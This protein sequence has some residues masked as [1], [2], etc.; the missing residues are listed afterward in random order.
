MESRVLIADDD[1]SIC[2]I[3]SKA[4]SKDGFVPEVVHRGQEAFERLTGQGAPRLALLDWMMPDLS[5][6]EVCRKL[7]TKADGTT[8]YVFL[9]SGRQSEEDML[10]GFDAGVDEFVAKPFD[11]QVLMARLHAA[12]RR[13]SSQ[14]ALGRRGLWDV[15]SGA[16]K[17]ATGEVIIRD[18]E[19]VG[20]IIL[21][22][23]KIAWI[24]LAGGLSLLPLLQHLG[25]EE[26]DAKLV[27]EECQRSKRPFL[28]TLVEW[29]LIL[30][31][32]LREQMRKELE[33]RL[34]LL[35]DHPQIRSFFLPGG[36][37]LQSSFTYKLGELTPL[38][39][40]PPSMPV[41]ELHDDIVAP[42]VAPERLKELLR[43]LARISGVVSVSLVDAPSGQQIYAAGTPCVE[44]LLHRLVRLLNAD[45]TSGYEEALLVGPTLY[46]AIHKLADG[47]LIYAQ[48]DRQQ[49]PNLG[50]IRF[51][52]G[53]LNGAPSP[54]RRVTR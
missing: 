20:R 1:V 29:G 24:Q 7:R 54:S 32:N 4:L 9:V 52:L 31:E 11:I 23:G 8:P 6:L 37:S 45:N 18:R 30:R 27:L 28:D 21:H 13:L 42:R 43:G 26:K 47:W 22:Q 44:S 46:H 15:L 17:G 35:L 10:Q 41:L 3:L 16:C 19:Q 25:V 14:E 51:E 34:E 12:E 48:V 38:L 36:A 5:G 33:K 39:D 53:L 2:N 49:N 40:P 50:Q